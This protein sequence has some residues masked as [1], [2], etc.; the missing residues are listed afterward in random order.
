MF[1][2][3]ISNQIP[4]RVIVNLDV[5]TNI[6]TKVRKVLGMIPVQDEEESYDRV[7]LS[8]LF[9]FQD[10]T[11]YTLELV[12]FDKTQKQLD[13]IV[14]EIDTYGT[15]P[16]RYHKSYKSLKQLV[17]ELPY[18]PEVLGVLDL[19]ARILAYGHWGMDY[20]QI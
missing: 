7:V 3:D 11:G 1:K 18:R 5:F 13:K 16:F 15:N 2:G 12:S 17:E 4:K 20:S 19:P 8:R 6:E 10:K 9:N 14:L